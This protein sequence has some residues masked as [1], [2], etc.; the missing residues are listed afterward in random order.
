MKQECGG[1]FKAEFSAA[2]FCTEELCTFLYERIA[3]CL[4]KEKEL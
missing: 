3:Y 4:I 2:L 1:K